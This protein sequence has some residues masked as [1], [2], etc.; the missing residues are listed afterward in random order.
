MSSYN[1]KP[2]ADSRE[3]TR[4]WREANPDKVKAN[5]PNWRKHNP[6]KARAIHNRRR[7]LE[8]GADGSFT[9]ED[10]QN[11]LAEQSNR[12]NY[13][14]NDLIN[15]YHV[16]HIQPLSRGGN[17]Y[18]YNLQLLCPVCNMKKHDLTDKEFRDK[19]YG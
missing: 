13:C 3:T 7:A 10:I 4:K 15:G 19:Y 8:S 2:V 18:S 12:C 16:D 17:N 14:G 9:G 5:V 6:E 11:L 1:R